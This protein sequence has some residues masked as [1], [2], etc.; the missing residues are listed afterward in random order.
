MI[1]FLSEDLVMA[2][3]EDLRIRVVE[4]VASGLSCRRAA[5]QFEA[6]VSSAIRFAKQ[7]AKE[8]HVARKIRGPGRRRLDAYGEDIIK[9]ITEMPDMALHEISARLK[10]VYD[11]RAPISTVDDW[12]R[13]QNISYKKNRTRQRAGTQ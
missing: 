7:Y 6:S 3:S 10:K 8:G 11:V 13:A 5:A 2:I 12:L 9:W 1:R 4:K